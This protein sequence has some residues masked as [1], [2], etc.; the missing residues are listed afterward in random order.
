[1]YGVYNIKVTI[2]EEIT[3]VELGI[4][5]SRFPGWRPGQYQIFMD[6][7]DCQ[8]RFSG[9]CAP[10]G[11]GK[12]LC[13]ICYALATGSR[14][15][16]LTPFKGLQ[17]QLGNEFP[18]TVT[19]LKGKANYHCSTMQTNCE[20][21][22][23]RCDVRNSIMGQGLCGHKAAINRAGH[24]NIV[25]TNYS[26]W[27]H[28]MYGAGIGDFDTI[29]MDEAD[30]AE[31][32]LSEFLSF[33]LSS[34]EALGDSGKARAPH[35]NESLVKWIEWSKDAIRPMRGMVVQ[36]EKDAKESD[37]RRVLERFFH[38]RNLYKKL[39]MLAEMKSEEWVCEP[40]KDG[41]RFDPIWPGNFAEKYLFRGIKRVI[42]FSGTLNRK[43]FELLGVK[44]DDYT[45]YDY[46]SPFHPGRNPLILA[47]IGNFRYPIAPELMMK[48]IDLFD[49]VVDQRK[50]T[51]GILHTISFPHLE[52]F[53]ER[54][55]HVNLFI[56]ND[57]KYA[58]GMRRTENVVDDFKKA[59]PPA[60]LASPSIRSGWDFPDDYC[61]YQYILKVP[62][63]DTQ[64]AVAKARKKLDPEYH[65]NLAMTSL[66]QMC[67]R[68]C[69][70]VYDY[71]ENIIGDVRVGW[72]LAN[73]KHLAAKW[74]LGARGSGRYRRLNAGAVPEP[75]RG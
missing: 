61:R 51:K 23:P 39:G 7:M 58:G 59:T 60:I 11:F 70:S 72:F 42:L 1:M 9:H 43:A 40:A 19:D 24:A 73:K 26:C 22:A 47:P 29:I 33:S 37:D 71:N 30:A 38:L 75:I 69:R 52:Q 63:P 17:D 5:E 34:K 20:M 4:D 18:D 21:G 54:S 10:C 68:P 44:Q 8:T 57:V 50:S 49:D 2:V 25:V 13:M 27:F 67:S 32:A 6:T 3:P 15:L 28:Q 48:A 65:D 66:I 14:T 46:D 36:A 31:S 45:F 56:S 62:F 12:S 55:R 53:I 41:I 64:S 16:I 35:W 74:F